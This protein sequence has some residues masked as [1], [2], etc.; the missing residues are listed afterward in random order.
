[1]GKLVTT[2][3]TDHEY[4]WELKEKKKIRPGKLASAK[5]LDIAYTCQMLLWRNLVIALRIGLRYCK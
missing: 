5:S 3:D 2:I 1:M 4:K